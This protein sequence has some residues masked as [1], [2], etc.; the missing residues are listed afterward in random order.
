MT[1]MQPYLSIII[2]AY[3]EALR[4]GNTLDAVFKFLSSKNFTY[5][6]IVVDDGSTDDTIAVVYKF[7]R[8]KILKNARN[9]GKG[10]SVKRGMLEAKGELRL[11]LDADHSVKIDNF[12][13]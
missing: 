9:M 10:Y 5:E 1:F 3:N 8:V 2:P 13:R 4:I 7:N 12:D 6:V 11:F